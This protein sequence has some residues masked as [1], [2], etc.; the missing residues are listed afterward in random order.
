M[1]FREEN[2]RIIDP[3]GVAIHPLGVVIHPLGALHKLVHGQPL[4]A[5][6]RGTTGLW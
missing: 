1:K 6:I 5:V 4:S 2:L 3:L